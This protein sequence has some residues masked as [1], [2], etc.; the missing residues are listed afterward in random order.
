M[1]RDAAGDFAWRA[2]SSWRREKIASGAGTKGRRGSASRF[3]DA[4]I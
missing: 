1:V 2:R 4:A 3:F